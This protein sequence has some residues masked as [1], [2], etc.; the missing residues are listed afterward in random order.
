MILTIKN[1]GPI[2]EYRC[3]LDRRLIVTYGVNSIGKSYAMQIEYLLLKN[4]LYW[5]SNRAGNG[6][7]N[8]TFEKLVKDFDES[9][10]ERQSI[11]EEVLAELENC[12]KGE[13]MST[14]IQS[15]DNT[16]SNHS[17]VSSGNAEIILE[18]PGIA[19]KLRFKDASLDLKWKIKP[20]VI[21]KSASTVHK[22]RDSKTEFDVYST[23]G[24]TEEPREVLMDKLVELRNEFYDAMVGEVGDIHFL[25]ASRSGISIGMNAIGPALAELSQY[26]MTSGKSIAIPSLP[27]PISDY[28]LELT[29]I[30][31]KKSTPYLYEAEQMEKR[32]LHGSV[33]QDSKKKT[34]LFQPEDM[35]TALDMNDASSMIAELS[36]VI[37]II[38]YMAGNVKKYN[39]RTEKNTQKES[40]IFIE[41]PEAHLH[42]ENQ[43]LLAEEFGRLA[44]A[45]LKIIAASHSNYIFNKFN[46]MILSKQLSCEDYEPIHLVKERKGAVSEI[47]ATDQYGTKDK[48][49]SQV[50]E[51]LY[52]E[53][54]QIIDEMMDDSGE[55]P[56]D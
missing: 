50:A 38:K 49:F 51:D 47:L 46:N 37:A 28:Y 4:L 48:N 54:E 11:T 10:Y 27:E 17:M 53:R 18:V 35:K 32:I 25:P 7:N 24:R 12:M 21:R 33:K 41:E 42:P 26:P 14:F 15:L 55:Q 31:S 6:T 29:R 45:G 3:D 43:V 16:F 44:K 40:I 20:I 23:K 36:P 8:H 5:N 34:L 1:F 19:V 56:D 9:D 2:S 39:D 22:S 52:D 30:Q 13:W